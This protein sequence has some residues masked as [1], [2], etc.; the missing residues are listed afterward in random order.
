MNNMTY[1]KRIQHEI[2]LL[3]QHYGN[4][5]DT[6]YLYA[7]LYKTK[8]INPNYCVYIPGRKNTIYQYMILFPTKF[9]FN[10]CKL[11]LLQD[12]NFEN[13][14]EYISYLIK[15]YRNINSFSKKYNIQNFTYKL[16]CPCC[17]SLSCF[18]N[19]SK[20]AIQ[21]IQEFEESKNTFIIIRQKM[22][23]YCLINSYFIQIQKKYLH[24]IVLHII[25]FL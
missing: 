12:G 20:R 9:P 5:F 8:N 14:I 3:E 22:I 18:W 11:Y 10:P 23:N 7:E 25:E 15:E 17:V 24:N 2:I 21:M 4:S 1:I 19:P 13:T 6:T 16:S